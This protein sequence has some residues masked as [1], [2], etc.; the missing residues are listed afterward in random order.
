MHALLF[1]FA[2]LSVGMAQQHMGHGPL[3]M[4]VDMNRLHAE[5]NNMIPGS[6]AVNFNLSAMHG[7]FKGGNICPFQRKLISKMQKGQRLVIEVLGGSATFGADLKKKEEERWTTRFQTVMNSG[8]YNGTGGIAVV[9]R[10][11]PACN[12]DAWIY[13]TSRFKDADM[14]IVDL[15]INDQGFDLPVL[16]LYYQ[17]L[18]QLLDELPNH[19]AILFVQ[20][21]RTSL[22]SKK[23]VDSVC[24]D[25]EK[26]GSCCTPTVYWCRKWWDMQD[27]VTVSL[28]KLKVPYVSYRDLVWPVY[29]S[30]PENLQSYWDG[31]SH[32]SAGVHLLYGKLVS[33]A[34]MRLLMLSHG[35]DTHNKCT[36]EGSD[37]YHA[38]TAGAEGAVGEGGAVT[39]ICGGDKYLTSMFA[40]DSA[41]SQHSFDPFL[42]R[43]SGQQQ[44]WR[45]YNDSK[46]KFGWILE[47]KP[48]NA[49]CEASTPCLDARTKISFEMVFGPAP[50]L[51]VTYLKSWS[52]DMG[53]AVLW[54]DEKRDQA[55]L[56]PG[57]WKDEYSVSH[58]TTI[59][60]T[61]Q[62]NVSLIM[63]GENFLMPSLSP[64]KHVVHIAAAS[65][66]ETSYF[67][68][69]TTIMTKKKLNNKF[70]WKLLGLQSC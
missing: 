39:A 61:R 14:V 28:R 31:L 4:H 27:Y 36:K 63:L 54:L 69:G 5:L 64:G 62:A 52:E 13:Q 26:H 41:A 51:Q 29:S 33:F 58:Y 50:T 2:L 8:W 6:A 7:V 11:I 40:N 43:D 60:P 65:L 53:T 49:S 35:A 21:F 10:A 16:T 1:F 56:L 15:S 45:F 23:E 19:P 38:G 24:P 46:E 44:Q 22:Q 20:G 70:K 37:R 25:A 34:F 48:E 18:V 59:T 47:A 57:Y 30:P 3:S 32:P 9:N 66:A 42:V 68:H 67:T 17:T 12:V 55:V